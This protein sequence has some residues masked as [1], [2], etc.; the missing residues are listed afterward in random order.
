MKTFVL[1]L[2]TLGVAA[3]YSAPPGSSGVVA[4]KAAQKS[5]FIPFDSAKDLGPLNEKINCHFC[6]FSKLVLVSLCYQN[7]ELISYR[8]WMLKTFILKKTMRVVCVVTG[9]NFE[10]CVSY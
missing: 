5:V 8:N 4:E 9:D 7:Y 3:V 1:L 2:A 6:C 10:H